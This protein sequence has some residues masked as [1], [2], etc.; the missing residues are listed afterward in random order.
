MAQQ[1]ITETMR[2]ISG[3]P[4]FLINFLISV[5]GSVT[6]EKHFQFLHAPGPIFHS[7][8]SNL[9]ARCKYSN[10]QEDRKQKSTLSSTPGSPICFLKGKKLFL[11]DPSS[12]DRLAISLQSNSYAS[13][14][15]AQL[16]F[17]LQ[18]PYHMHYFALWCILSVFGA[19]C[20]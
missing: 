6:A 11:L 18:Q 4:F 10:T 1:Q 15:H 9:Q 20:L 12:K 19:F 8:K 2:C 14:V 13:I 16:P 17:C 3:F 5:S 7:F